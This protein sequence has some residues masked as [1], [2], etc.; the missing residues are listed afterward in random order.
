MLVER[1]PGPEPAADRERDRAQRLGGENSSERRVRSGLADV[2]DPPERRLER[3]VEERDR[4]GRQ[5]LAAGNLVWVGRGRERE[6]E[7]GAGGGRRRVGEPLDDRGKL[8][9]VESCCVHRV[10]VRTG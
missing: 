1:G 8:E 10:S 2:A 4:L 7:L 9:R 3:L 5:R 6:R